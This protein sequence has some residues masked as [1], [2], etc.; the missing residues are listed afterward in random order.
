LKS[1]RESFATVVSV[2][3]FEFSTAKV[4]KSPLKKQK[5]NKTKS[6]VTAKSPKKSVKTRLCLSYSCPTSEIKA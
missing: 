5:V 4:F 3:K 6:E 1:D 2:L